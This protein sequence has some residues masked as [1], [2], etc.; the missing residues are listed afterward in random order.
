MRR[1]PGNVLFNQCLR[2]K[3]QHEGA[4]NR[5][6]AI[7]LKLKRLLRAQAQSVGGAAKIA[8]EELRLQTAEIEVR[9]T[10]DAFQSFVARWKDRQAV[11]SRRYERPTFAKTEDGQTMSKLPALLPG[12]DIK[13]MLAATRQTQ[14]GIGDAIRKLD[15]A[16]DRLPPSQE[17]RSLRA[18]QDELK[19]QAGLFPDH[20]PSRSPRESWP[21]EQLTAK[22][23]ELK[24]AA[25]K[26]KVTGRLDKA[27]ECLKEARS[28][29]EQA[30]L[31]QR[32]AP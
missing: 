16:I 2:A 5:R 12:R 4:L 25:R 11:S 22:A 28:L 26:W 10:F 14:E 29:E 32:P 8:A 21:A 27:R 15:A 1:N 6:S 18:R 24:D 9:R 20:E 17:K 3:R 30:A 7:K 31:R 13:A 23:I 19:Q